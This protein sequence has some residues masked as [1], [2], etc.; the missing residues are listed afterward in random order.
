MIRLPNDFSGSNLTYKIESKDD[1]DFSQIYEDRQ[2]LP[3]EILSQICN[4]RSFFLTFSDMTSSINE[5]KKINYQEIIFKIPLVFENKKFIFP[6]VS[7]VSDPYSFLRGSYLG[8]YK[9]MNFLYT[10]SVSTQKFSDPNLISISIP[11]IHEIFESSSVI[12]KELSA[13]FLLHRCYTIFAPSD[14]LCDLNIRNYECSYSESFKVPNTK[15]GTILN[16]DLF[17]NEY[18]LTRDKFTLEGITVH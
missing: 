5:R 15:I 14:C 9:K 16:T 11:N 17:S 8:F 13:P 7:Y 12:N 10:R 4:V 3:S 6:V 2:T 1:I 18:Y